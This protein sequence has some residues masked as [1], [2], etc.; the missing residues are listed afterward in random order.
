MK[1]FEW[2]DAA[3]KHFC[4][5]YTSTKREKDQAAF[6]IDNY[7]GKRMQG[8]L[9]QFKQDW[10]QQEVVH[11]EQMAVYKSQLEAEMKEKLDQFASV[12]GIKNKK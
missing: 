6:P 12:Y 4:R 11:L 8:K 1:Q 9:D 7:R 3:V 2:T 5:I 10:M